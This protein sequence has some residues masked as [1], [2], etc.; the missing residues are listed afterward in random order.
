MFIY[1]PHR[2]GLAESMEEVK[3]FE[4][5]LEMKKYVVESY[6][7]IFGFP[8]FSIDDIVI[9]KEETNDDRIGWKDTKYVCIMRMGNETYK[10]PQCVG[11]C[12][13]KYNRS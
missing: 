5:E 7:Y 1:R 8:L 13:T 6:I 9:S 12:A 2:G 4:N 3:E 11:M 10:T